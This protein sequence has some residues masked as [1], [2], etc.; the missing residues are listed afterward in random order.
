M[1]RIY[2]PVR[3]I[4][5]LSRPAVFPVH[6]VHVPHYYRDLYANLV[7]HPLMAYALP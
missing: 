1:E 3:L 2:D 4:K 7:R 5:T 6:L